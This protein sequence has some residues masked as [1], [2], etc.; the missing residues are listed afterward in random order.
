M[1]AVRSGG[2]RRREQPCD[3]GKDRDG[4]TCAALPVLWPAHAG[5]LLL[6]REGCFGLYPLV[7]GDLAFPP[8][9]LT[10]RASRSV[11]SADGTGPI[12]RA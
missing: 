3:A 9:R 7:A 4:D 11:R 12:L 8:Y 5:Y 6:S 1:V 10:A 2:H